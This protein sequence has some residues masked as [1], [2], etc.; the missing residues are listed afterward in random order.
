MG[1]DAMILVFWMLS[2]KPTFSLSS[3]T[4]IK[5]LFCSSS[6]SATWI[7]S[8]LHSQ[9]DPRQSLLPNSTET[10]FQR[11]GCEALPRMVPSTQGPGHW[12]MGRWD[13][14]GDDRPWGKFPGECVYVPV[15]G[16]ILQSQRWLVSPKKGFQEGQTENQLRIWF[17]LRK[18]HSSFPAFFPPLPS[19]FLRQSKFLEV[20]LA[21]GK[22]AASGLIPTS[23]LCLP[24]P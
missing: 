15:S 9:K 14:S 1:A 12:V 7:D 4:F 16:R 6:L 3:F 21:S 8:R 23:P 22:Q 19:F 24:Q 13:L 20:D 2:F 11:C 17:Y 18:S 10:P 5:R